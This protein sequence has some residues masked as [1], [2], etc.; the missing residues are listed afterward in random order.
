MDIPSLTPEEFFEMWE[1]ERGV[2]YDEIEL[3]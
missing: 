2:L 3:P 1:K